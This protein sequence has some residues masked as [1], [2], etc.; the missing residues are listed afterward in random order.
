MRKIRFVQKAFFSNH[1]IL[2]DICKNIY[3]CSPPK[4][5]Q[6]SF[7]IIISENEK[8]IKGNK[9]S[10][11]A[12]VPSFQD[13][14]SRMAIVEKSFDF[15]FYQHIPLKYQCGDSSQI[16]RVSVTMILFTGAFH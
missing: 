2:F 10:S 16:L 11:Q 5:T 13:R 7:Q 14:N 9:K 6:F 1:G 4:K 8:V 12:M 15:I 3:R